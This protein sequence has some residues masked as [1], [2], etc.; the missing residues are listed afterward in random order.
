MTK[1]QHRQVHADQLAPNQII[2]IT[3]IGTMFISYG[4]PICTKFND[5][6]I[7]L[8]SA[9]RYSSTTSKYRSRFLDESTTVTQSKLNSGEYKLR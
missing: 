6:K 7:E 8:Y 3:P 5:G 4:T 2:V 1:K 9:W